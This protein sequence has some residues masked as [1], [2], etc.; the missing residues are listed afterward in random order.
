MLQPKFSCD[1]CGKLGG[2][3]YEIKPKNGQC[4]HV[5]Q[6]CKMGMITYLVGIFEGCKS[7]KWTKMNLG[8][9]ISKNGK[10]P[11]MIDPKKEFCNKE[12]LEEIKYFYRC[13]QKNKHNFDNVDKELKKAPTYLKIIGIF[14]T[15][16]ELFD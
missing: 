4:L 14:C 6:N 5:H 9:I 1:L 7:K 12:V 15:W 11:Q 13:L 10:N 2:L 3:L 8:N 16:N